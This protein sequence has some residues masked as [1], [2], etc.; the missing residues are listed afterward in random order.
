M[1]ERGNRNQGTRR[2]R[3][4]TL[5]T[6]FLFPLSLFPVLSSAQVP[7]VRARADLSLSLDYRNQSDRANL[8]LYNPLGRPSTVTL[9]LLLEPGFTVLVSERLQ[10]LPGD[11]ENDIFD[12][13]YIED[14]GIWR[15]GKQYLP[16]G[17]GRLLRESVP[18]ARIDSNLIAERVPVT[19]ALFNAGDGRQ[20]GFVVRV[21]RSVGASVANG[22]HL[23]ISGTSLGV[24]RRPSDAPGKGSGWKRAFGMDA[25]RRFGKLGLS[26]EIGFFTGGPLRDLAVSDLEATY[27]SDNYR[28]V[29]L[30][31]SHASGPFD[32]DTL[33]FFGRVRAARNVDLE[34]LVRWKDNAFY[35]ASVTLRVRL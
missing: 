13:V 26:A 7:D 34:P 9:T 19:L 8:R 4:S 11:A 14:P 6:S 32:G 33:R 28:T 15:V 2:N 29:G 16:F 27:F 23:G 3:L 35:D 18:A 12:E 20:N 24:I 1:R 10:R 25:S 17:A 31:F 30:G 22:E 5:F 21:G